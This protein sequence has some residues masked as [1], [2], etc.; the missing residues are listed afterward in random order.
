MKSGSKSTPVRVRKNFNL[1]EFR[2]AH[3]SN[4]C[5]GKFVLQIVAPGDFTG[6]ALG[7]VRVPWIPYVACQKC[8]ASYLAPGFQEFI[9]AV[10][11]RALVFGSGMLTKPQL[12][13]L[14][15]HFDHTQEDFAKLAEISDRHEMSK[16]ESEHFTTKT[17]SKESQVLLRLKLARLLGEKDSEHLIAL[18]DITA[19]PISTENLDLP[20]AEEIKRTFMG[21]A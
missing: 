7:V 1:D 5:G 17:L 20:T 14:R 8:K 3:A 4:E 15:Q 12:K 18:A 13:F 16:F 6:S 2:N 9:E 21:A 11:A 10:I 19:E